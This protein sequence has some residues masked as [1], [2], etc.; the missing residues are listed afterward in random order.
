M[1]LEKRINACNKFMMSSWYLKN[2]AFNCSSVF[3]NVLYSCIGLPNIW[4]DENL[5]KLPPIS[6][7][8]KFTIFQ[9]MKA[10]KF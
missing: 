2:T 7:K 5:S 8:N 1:R 4:A 10:L 9:N 3:L 6:Q